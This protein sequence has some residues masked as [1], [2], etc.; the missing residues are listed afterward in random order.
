MEAKSTTSCCDPKELTIQFDGL[1]KD[2][3]TLRRVDLPE[4]LP[5]SD[6]R[7]LHRQLTECQNDYETLRRELLPKPKFVF[8]RYRHAWAGYN[9]NRD[10]TDEST[11]SECNKYYSPVQKDNERPEQSE[12]M[13]LCNLEHSNVRVL[14]DGTVHI[15]DTP[16]GQSVKSGQAVVLRNIK[17]CSIEL[18]AFV[19]GLKN[20]HQQTRSIPFHPSSGYS[21]HVGRCQAPHCEFCSFHRLSSNGIA[22]RVSTAATAFVQRTELS[23][24]RI[25]RSKSRRL[26]PRPHNG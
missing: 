6:V 19:P 17:Q 13:G 20:S 22:T 2:L 12:Q 5:L 7:L 23:G 9:Q 11:I 4:D 8:R 10:Q 16:I 18:Y 1:N 24:E 21:R 14:A 25:G 26:P 15:N 3:K